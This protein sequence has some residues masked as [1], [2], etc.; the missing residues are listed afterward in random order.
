MLR[1]FFL[2]YLVLF[3]L[4]DRISPGKTQGN[5]QRLL[6]LALSRRMGC[7]IARRGNHHKPLLLLVVLFTELANGGFQHLK[8][9]ELAVLAQ[10]RSASVAKSTPG[11]P[12]ETKKA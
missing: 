12:P 3:G 1:P 6:Q 2:L 4:V 5:A 11:S 9:V 7:Q 8:A 10:Q